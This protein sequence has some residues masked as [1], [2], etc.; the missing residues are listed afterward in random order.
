MKVMLSCHASIDL[1]LSMATQKPIFSIK[2]DCTKKTQSE[3]ALAMSQ[4]ILPPTK[5]SALSV[6]FRG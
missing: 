5:L 3:P 2:D 6:K 1:A 4:G